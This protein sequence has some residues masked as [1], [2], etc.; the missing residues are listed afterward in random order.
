MLTFFHSVLPAMAA[1]V[2]TATSTD[3]ACPL[4]TVHLYYD[5]T[6]LFRNTAKILAVRDTEV[7][8]VIRT[9]VILDQTVMHPQGGQ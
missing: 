7:D 4:T 2:G 3:S 5:D 8:G 9:I 6:Y 1:V